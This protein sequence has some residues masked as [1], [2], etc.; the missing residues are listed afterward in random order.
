MD[1]FLKRIDKQRHGNDEKKKLLRRLFASNDKQ[2][3]KREDERRHTVDWS[4][5]MMN[6]SNRIRPVV[7]D[8]E[9]EFRRRFLG[10]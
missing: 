4:S 5:K 8:S 2:K 10:L 7:A 6:I 3:L 9:N 1:F